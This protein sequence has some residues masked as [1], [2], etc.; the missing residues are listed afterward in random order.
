MVRFWVSIMISSP[1]ML[2]PA[3]QISMEFYLLAANVGSVLRTH[4]HDACLVGHVRGVHLLYHQS[5]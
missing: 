3:A 5:L 2:T 1:D 4:E